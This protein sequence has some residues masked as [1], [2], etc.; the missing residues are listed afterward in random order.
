MDNNKKLFEKIE[1]G[2]EGDKPKTGAIQYICLLLR[3][4]KA[5]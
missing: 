3:I 5:G 2:I 4:K 1:S